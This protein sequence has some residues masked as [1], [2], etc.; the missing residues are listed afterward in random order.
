M[1]YLIFLLLSL[2]AFASDSTPP[3]Q[4]ATIHVYREKA[5]LVGII[6]R[7]SIYFDGRELKR[8]AKGE[9]FSIALPIGKHLISAGRSEVGNLVE[10]EPGKDYFF[11]L[12]HKNWAGNAVTGRQPMFLA[13]MPADQARTEMEGLTRVTATLPPAP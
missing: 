11:K 6:I 13:P 2:A 4:T 8:L 3:A 10:L 5:R 9:C 1:R 12:D 7:P